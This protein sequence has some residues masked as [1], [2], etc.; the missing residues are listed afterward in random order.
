MFVVPAVI[1]PGVVGIVL[2]MAKDFVAET[3]QDFKTIFAITLPVV[4]AVEY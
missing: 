2:L 1:T 4:N 3:L